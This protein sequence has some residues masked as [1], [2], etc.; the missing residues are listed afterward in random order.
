MSSTDPIARER[1]EPG[2]WRRGD[3]YEI[4]FRDA[5]GKQR[6]RVV[7]G[8]I[9]AAR[10]ALATEIARRATGER[11]AADTRLTLGRAADHW[12]DEHVTAHLR[13]ASQ[14][15]A[16]SALK[17]LRTEFG[18]RRLTAIEPGDVARYVT[19]KR[20][21]GLADNTVRAHVNTL[22]G[23]YRFAIRHLGFPGVN[24]VSVLDARERPS[25]APVIETRALTSDEIVRLLDETLPADLLLTE[26]GLGTGMR[27]SEILGLGWDDLD[28]GENPA[29]TVAAQLG[30]YGADR[31]K[32]VAVKSRRG[33]RR[34]VITADLAPS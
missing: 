7:D 12:Y 10:N 33:R 16:R 22:S 20:A 31:G 11:V 23:I 18:S 19:R 14:S 27:M 4:T 3:T 9:M 6:R 25:T 26:L 32:R 30:R 2:I 13:P 29:V 17:H 34:I 24:P 1:V 28:L 21:A 8:G 15:S 5:Q